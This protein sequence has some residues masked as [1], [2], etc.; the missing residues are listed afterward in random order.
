MS[1]TLK[2]LLRC[3]LACV[4]CYESSVLNRSTE[5]PNIIAMLDTAAAS[6]EPL[7]ALHGGEIMLLTPIE[8]RNLCG[9]LVAQGKRL[10]MQTNATLLTDDWMKLIQEY[11]IEVGVSLNGPGPL[12]R[13][14]WAGS[15]EAT[16]RMTE[17]VHRNV[18]RLADAGRLAGVI[19]VLSTHNAGDDHQLEA[20]IE[21]AGGLRTNSIRWNP[22]FGEGELTPN[23]LRKVYRRLLHATV[24]NKDRAWLPFREWI[25][26]LCGL[27]LMP[28]WM[29]PCDPYHTDAVHTVFGD[30]SEGNCLRTSPDG[31]PWQRAETETHIRQEILFQIPMDQ[32][33]CGGCR[34]FNF[35]H[36]GCPAEA[37]DGDWRNKTR[38]CEAIK[39]TYE[40]IE[41]GLSGWIPT[42]KSAAT[43]DH[44]DPE[45]LARSIEDRKPLISAFGAMMRP[46]GASTFGGGNG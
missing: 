42:W 26:N 28:C 24:A 27:G 36:G 25:D 43:W 13:A 1:L 6:S 5:R 21:W 12:N 30:G 45:A 19:V 32:G 22:L 31:T 11:K 16:D 20:L 15:E 33:G 14:R 4:G 29:K 18:E 9:G 34:F 23:R 2:P 17:R 40:A 3:N 44:A 37:V 7:A 10:V 38:W 41:A 39:A 8:A 35:C 46:T